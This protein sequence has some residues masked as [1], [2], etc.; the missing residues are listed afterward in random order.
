MMENSRD[1]D[2]NSFRAACKAY[3]IPDKLLV[4]EAW[5]VEPER[6]LGAGNKTL[7]M[8][9]AAPANMLSRSVQPKAR[10]ATKPTTSANWCAKHW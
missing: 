9:M 2:V 5:D 3:G 6:V 1:P 8:A 4:A 7:E 10:A